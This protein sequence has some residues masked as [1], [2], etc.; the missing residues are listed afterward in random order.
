MG[1]H[2]RGSGPIRGGVGGRGAVGQQKKTQCMQNDLLLAVCV[3]ANE[4]GRGEV[5]VGNCA[6]EVE[7]LDVGLLREGVVVLA[8]DAW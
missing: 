7:Q 2:K 4:G 6:L 1:M 3:D 8:K 5:A